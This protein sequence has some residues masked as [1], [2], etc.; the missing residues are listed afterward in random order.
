MYFNSF[1]GHEEGGIIINYRS[2]ANLNGD[3]LEYEIT[4]YSIFSLAGIAA[5]TTMGVNLTSSCFSTSTYSLPR[6]SSSSG[7]LLPL[8]GADYCAPSLNISSNSGLGFYRDTVILPGKCANFRFEVSSGFGR[9]NFTANIASSFGTNYF[10]VTLDNLNG[11]NS[12]PQVDQSDILQAACLLKPLTLYGFIEPDGD[13][14]VYKPSTPLNISGSTITPLSYSLGYSRLNPVNSPSGY[15]LDST[16]GVVKTELNTVGAFAIGIQF[17]EYRLDTALGFKVLIA[18]GRFIMNLIGASSCSP[19]PIEI[20]HS[21]AL[22]SDSLQCGEK[23]IEIRTTRKADL[24]SMTSTG[25]EFNISS[26][27]NPSLNIIAAQFLSETVIK[28]ELNQTINS[29]DTISLSISNGTDQNTIISVCGKEVTPITDTLVFYSPLASPLNSQ[30]TYS[31]NFLDL[32]FQSALADSVVWDFGDGSPVLINANNPNHIFQ[33]PG[34]YTV[35][36]SLFNYCGDVWTSAQTINVCDSISADLTYSIS[37]DTLT[38]DG[39]SSFGA[40]NYHWNFGDGDSSISASGNHVFSTGGTYTVVLYAINDCGDSSQVSFQVETCLAPNAFWTYTILSTTQNGMDVNF[41]GTSSTNATRYIWDFGD[42]T[43]DSSSL[44]PNHVYQTP[45]LSYLVSLTIFNTCSDMANKTYRLDQIGLE[46][47]DFIHSIEIYPNPAKD[48]IHF[49][50]NTEN[51]KEIKVAL[52]SV[53][54]KKVMEKNLTNESEDKMQIDID[55]L[56]PGYYTIE[57]KN[58]SSNRFYKIL[59]Q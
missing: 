45:S 50:W 44:S 47:N 25:S 43:L 13:S 20:D 40:N 32:N 51:E 39:S 8:L 16:N 52:Y 49:K 3:S 23:F 22:N 28:L 46:E 14:V 57:I 10:F 4:I 30:F 34:S 15:F 24:T 19:L 53:E 18:K 26:K 6:V 56:N 59:I 55:H 1:A 21:V 38:F 36:L 9:Y 2:L 58:S 5:P 11:P 41:D 7:G 12:C 31:S 48:I 42:G 35:Q 33:T 17:E 54:G 29:N 27:R 37:G